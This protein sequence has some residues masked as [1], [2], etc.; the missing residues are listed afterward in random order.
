MGPRASAGTPSATHEQAGIATAGAQGGAE[1]SVI[2]RLQAD[3]AFQ[4]ALRKR[5]HPGMVMV[6]T[7]T[8]L[9]PDRRSGED[10]VI[11]TST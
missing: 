6:V 4:G 10:F 11:M 5:M 8:P 9:H 2:A 7:D 1:A 3:A